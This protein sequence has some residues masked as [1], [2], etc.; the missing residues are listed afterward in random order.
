MVPKDVDFSLLDRSAILGVIFYPRKSFYR[1][2]SKP[3]VKNHLVEV[4]KGIK[5]GC[6][7][8]TKG[9]DYPSLLYFH[10]NGEMHAC[11]GE[12]IL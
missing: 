5:I 11:A 10:G 1:K 3:N 2:P 4:E 12:K 6:R 8:Y 7:F 9:L